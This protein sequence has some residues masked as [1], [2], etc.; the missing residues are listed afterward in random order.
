MKALKT[1]NLSKKYG[2]FEALKN[3]NFE[4]ESG[5]FF[6]LLGVNG[7]GKTTIIGIITDLVNKSSGEVRVF[8]KSID[9]HKEIAKSM[10]GVVPQ[11]FNFD[12]FTKLKDVITTQAGY[13][14]IDK[15][16]AQKRTEKLLKELDLWEKR[17]TIMM[18]LSGGMKRRAMIARA[19][20]NNPKLLI[21]DEPTAGVDINVRKTTWKYLKQINKSGTTILLTTHYLEEVEQLCNAIAVINKGEIIE[22]CSKKELF[23]KVEQSKYQIILKT[24]IKE[25]PKSLEKFSA[26]K[27]NTKTIEVSL[28]KKDS[29]ND[30]L[31][32]LLKEKIEIDDVNNVTNELEQLFTTLTR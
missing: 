9:T 13:Y 14:G 16:T 27:K 22:N 15:K 11:E 23:G 28:D 6:A 26:K 5:D 8:G 19:L 3:I 21:L 2:S 1:K 24:G 17:D 20:V 4:I 32:V 25:L 18:Q 10:I 7:A 29:L 30:L 31:K 12:I